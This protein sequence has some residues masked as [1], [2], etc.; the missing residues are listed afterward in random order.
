MTGEQL[1]VFGVLAATLVLFVWNRWR[2]DLVALGALLACALTGVVPADEVFS[3]IGHPAV[4]SVAAVLVLS[5]GL[6]NA[7][8]VDSVARRLMQ[9]GERPWA[10]VAA[11]TGIVAL[12]SGF[13]NNVGAL[14]L[15]M[16]VAIWMSRQS[17]RSP[18][19]LLMPLAFGSL[20]GGTL[21]LIGTP[22]NLI[23]AGYRAE[24]GEAPFGM[25]AF[26]PV[27]AAVTVAGVLFI[28]LLGWRLVPRRQEQEGNGD[29]FEISAYLT[30][31]RVPE[32]CKY[33]GR[34]LH[35]LINA[36]EDEADVQVIALVRGDERQ[37]MPSTYEVLREGDILLVE[38]D[39]DSLKALLDVTGVALAAHVDE[40]EEK[41]QKEQEAAEQAVEDE[42]TEKNHKSR[43]GELTLAEAIVSPGS[44]LVGTTASGLDLRERHGVN[45]LAVARQGQRL[46]QRLG[47]IRFA[48]GDI[49][50]LQARE[51]ALQSSL[52]SLGCLPLAS[53]GLSIT[54]PRNVLLASAIFAITLACIAFG[55]VPAATALV[56]GALVMILVGL[57]PVGRIYDSIDMPVIVLVAAM[58]PVGE[59]LESSGGSQLIA[60][61][62]LELGQSLPAA[63][64][65]ALLMVAVMLIS[66]V[67]NNAAAAVLAA[68]VAISLARGMDVSA[69]P[70]L[71][72]V[73]IGA[74]CAFLTPIGHQSNTLV[75][76]PGGYRFGDYW[77]LGLPLSILVV[78][79]AVPAILWIWPL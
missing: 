66:N 79:C 5:R 15:F 29:L 60:E 52:N 23:I 72:A 11:L 18:S 16:P 43:H 4:I 59:A 1:I 49:L 48:S 61:T 22:P 50:L 47:K 54:T 19:Y 58:L 76:A 75:M 51:D 17:G 78:L 34:T 21:T 73:A 42:K 30:E 26:L 13:M 45:V 3:G 25:F 33:A 46:R 68:P 8:V 74:S 9:V 36:V 20:L 2:Y 10:Q 63:A 6:L 62:L 12:S 55:L 35:A 41:A 56:T 67:V 70:F 28:A 53:R 69:D 24:A 57:I 39:S 71:M 32:S 77:R 38:A 7:G 31:V 27:G 40:Q 64:T 65:L 37:R 44:I 14:A